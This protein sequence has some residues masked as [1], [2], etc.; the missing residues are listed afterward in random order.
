VIYALNGLS[1]RDAIDVFA[2]LRFRAAAR[3]ACHFDA[4]KLCMVDTVCVIG[5]YRSCP[6][7]MG[8]LKLQSK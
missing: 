1:T 8:S 6:V 3:E 4:V 2:S 5:C 7:R